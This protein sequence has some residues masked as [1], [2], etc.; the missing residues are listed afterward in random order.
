MQLSA[1]RLLRYE[2]RRAGTGVAQL[3]TAYRDHPAGSHLVMG[4]GG[5]WYIG[6]PDRGEPIQ[7][8]AWLD[9]WLAARDASIADLIFESTQ[10]KAA[11]EQEFGPPVS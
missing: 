4:V 10:A 11:F 3:M 2:A 8:R 5:S 6:W 7:D 1:A 9:Q